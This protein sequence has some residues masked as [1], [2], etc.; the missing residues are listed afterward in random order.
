MQP[1]PPRPRRSRRRLVRW[2]VAAGVAVVVLAVGA[3]FVYT[4]FIVADAP[5]P[6][7]SLSAETATSAP[8][9]AGGAG[10]AT[11]VD[12]V[13]RAGEGSEAGYRVDEVL[14]GQNTT[15]V[16]RTTRVT[17]EMTVTGSTVAA[18]S[19]SVDLASVTSDSERRD[20]QFRT[21]IMEVARFPTA[22]FRLTQPME[23]GAVPAVGATVDAQ[24]VGELTLRGA[25]R[26]VT[27]Q[28]RAR[29][30]GDTIT[31]STSIPVVFA[32]FGVPNPSIGPIS[33][34]DNGT[35]EVL[36]TLRRG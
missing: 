33:T 11:S 36:L 10:P 19:F 12:G 27:A 6:P 20:G 8:P 9:A 23:L 1:E 34:E 16:G 22:D 24:G 30:D 26:P 21:R 7:L 15:A 18:A 4:R 31:V 32:D 17:G 3:P 28:L 13:W 14:A 5:P 29:R 2:L 25:T 35:V